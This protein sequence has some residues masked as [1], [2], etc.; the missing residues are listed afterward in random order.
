MTVLMLVPPCRNGSISFLLNAFHLIGHPSEHLN[1]DRSSRVIRLF[2]SRIPSIG[3]EE[4]VRR[5]ALIGV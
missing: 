1:P 3:H 2:S 4:L 5:L